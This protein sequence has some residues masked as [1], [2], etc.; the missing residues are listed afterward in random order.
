MHQTGLGNAG[1]RRETIPHVENDSE[2]FGQS[3]GR[4]FLRLR[5]SELLIVSAEI[6]G[7]TYRQLDCQEG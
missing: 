4:E 1:H 6:A 3:A 2:L 5:G 7:S